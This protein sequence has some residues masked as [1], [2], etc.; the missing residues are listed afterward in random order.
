MWP[1]GTLFCMTQMLENY[2]QY[3]YNLALLNVVVGKVLSMSV[4]ELKSLLH[5]SK[6]PNFACII[7]G[8]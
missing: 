3:F 4:R 1:S 7:L 2:N 6:N 5:V 8:V